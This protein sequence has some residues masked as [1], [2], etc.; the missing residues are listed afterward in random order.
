MIKFDRILRY[1]FPVMTSGSCWAWTTTMLFSRSVVGTKLL[2][3]CL[4]ICI[5]CVLS[6]QEPFILCVYFSIEEGFAV[7]LS[8]LLYWHL[9]ENWWAWPLPQ[10]F[11]G[12]VHPFGVCNCKNIQ[13]VMYL[14][15]SVVTL[16]CTSKNIVLYPLIC[17]LLLVSG[18]TT[19][20][21]FFSPN[22]F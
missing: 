5:R 21:T 13:F 11:S 1:G 16:S 14:L 4:Y 12:E 15:L 3:L 18:D 20:W 6:T 10:V 19:N 17:P 22:N 7:L 2:S 8:G 9:S